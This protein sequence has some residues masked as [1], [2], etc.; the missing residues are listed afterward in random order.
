MMPNTLCVNGGGLLRTAE[1][2]RFVNPPSG[3]AK[4]CNAQIDDY[5]GLPRRRFPHRPPLRLALAHV[6]RTLPGCCPARQ[7]LVSGM[8]LF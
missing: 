8:I 3:G 7:G 1:G 6:S 2:L 4:Y 5:Q